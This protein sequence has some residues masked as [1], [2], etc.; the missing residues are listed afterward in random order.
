MKGQSYRKTQL[1]NQ[2]TFHSKIIEIICPLCDKKLQIVLSYQDFVGRKG[3]SLL[4]RAIIHHDHV[5]SLAIDREGNIRRRCAIPL[6]DPQRLQQEFDMNLM[7][8]LTFISNQ[9][10]KRKE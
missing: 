10:L 8:L 3:D 6:A 5:I 4:R 7:E 1:Y 9:S 2:N